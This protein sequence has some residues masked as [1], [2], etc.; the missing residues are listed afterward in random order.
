MKNFIDY[1]FL[2]R[3]YNNTTKKWIYSHPSLVTKNLNIH[4]VDS[5]AEFW[6]V[7]SDCLRRDCI[8]NDW[9][10][11]QSSGMLDQNDTPIFGEDIVEY[12]FKENPRD[13]FNKEPDGVGRFFWNDLG[14]CFSLELE[15]GNV[16]EI[17]EDYDLWK[18]NILGNTFDNENL[19]KF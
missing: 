16:E 13:K 1:R 6:E 10:V 5:Y 19:L 2:F 3:G 15:D 14:K 17:W 4:T 11:T 18:F 9:V 12:W 7:V 8:G